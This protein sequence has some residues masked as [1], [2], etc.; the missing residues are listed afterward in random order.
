M[1]L[2]IIETFVKL[3]EEYEVEGILEKW[4]I[5]EKTHYLIK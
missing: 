1:P 4:M 5:S 2:Q 3:N